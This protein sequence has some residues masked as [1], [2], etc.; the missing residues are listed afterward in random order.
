MDEHQQHVKNWYATL[1]A[2]ARQMELNKEE[3]AC[4]HC[5]RPRSE[6]YDKRCTAYVTSANFRA[7]NQEEVDKTSAM[8][9]ALENLVTVCGWSLP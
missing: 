2:K 3:T 1:C 9:V 5:D 8:I 6:H 4:I 7:I